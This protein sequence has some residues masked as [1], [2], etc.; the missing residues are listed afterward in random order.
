MPS[1]SRIDFRGARALRFLALVVMMYGVSSTTA[2]A[3]CDEWMTAGGYITLVVATPGDGAF[4]NTNGNFG[5]SGGIKRGKLWGS[6]NYVDHVR[7]MH[8]LGTKVTSYT[9][10]DQFTREIRGLCKIDGSRTLYGYTLQLRD[11][12]EPGRQDSF[13]LTL[14]TGYMAGGLLDGGNVQ[15][16]N[17]CLGCTGDMGGL[18]TTGSPSDL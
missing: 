16:H 3:A 2:F 7:D 15:L 13:C 4:V 11:R 17:S 10:V 1:I 12:G 14:S 6:L 9:C 5:A 18:C 8:V